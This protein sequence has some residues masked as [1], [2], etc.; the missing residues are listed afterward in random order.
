MGILLT[1]LW[2]LPQISLNLSCQGLVVPCTYLDLPRNSI[3]ALG[4]FLYNYQFQLSRLLPFISRVADL[5]QRESLIATPGERLQTQ[6]MARQIGLALHEIIYAT[7]PIAHLIRDVQLGESSGHFHLPSHPSPEMAHFVAPYMQAAGH[8][9]NV[10]GRAQVPPPAISPQQAQELEAALKALKNRLN[11]IGT[12]NAK[13]NSMTEADT[14]KALIDSINTNLGHMIEHKHWQNKVRSLLPESLPTEKKHEQL[15]LEALSMITPPE[16]YELYKGNFGVIGSIV[17][18]ALKSIGAIDK[19]LSPEEEKAVCNNLIEEL[20]K[21]V[22]VPNELKESILPGFEPITGIAK[23]LEEYFNKILKTCITYS[24]DRD[25]RKLGNELRSLVIKMIETSIRELSEGFNKEYS[26]A[27]ILIKH[28][29]ELL[30]KKFNLN[31]LG[32]ILTNLVG[33]ELQRFIENTYNQSKNREEEKEISK[34]EQKTTEVVKTEVMKKPERKEEKKEAKKTTNEVNIPEEW[35]E[36]I[37][38]DM[39]MQKEIKP[40]RPFSHAYVATDRKKETKSLMRE[41]DNPLAEEMARAL[42]KI[43]LSKDDVMNAINNV[44]KELEDIYFELLRLEFLK[45]IKEDTDYDPTKY[46]R[47]CMFVNKGHGQ[48]VDKGKVKS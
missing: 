48:D 39:E 43:N 3:T 29:I 40:R 13:V 23:V 19:A 38:N 6:R 46:E 15:L 35:K 21:A 37:E 34:T 22:V 41:F 31:G 9:V 47:L 10:A 28:N 33:E 2:V 14:A 24:R 42:R 45:R 18:V 36:I 30:L 26:D 17:P 20:K 32:F 11:E 25:K 27:I 7:A 8:N 5:F 44:D 16:V 12:M 1:L 4:V